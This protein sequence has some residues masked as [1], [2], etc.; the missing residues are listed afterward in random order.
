[1]L[2]FS[3]LPVSNNNGTLTATCTFD[4][5]LDLKEWTSCW[6]QFSLI[7]VGILAM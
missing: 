5:I 1:M 7:T 6:W 4:N 2:Q 3:T